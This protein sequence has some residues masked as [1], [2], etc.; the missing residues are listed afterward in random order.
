MHI[1]DVVAA[2]LVAVTLATCGPAYAAVY[3]E[4]LHAIELD[5]QRT[6]V[7]LLKRGVDVNT[8]DEKGDTLLILAARAGKPATVQ[9]LLAY[10]P[11]L[12][13]RN[14]VGESALMHAA[15]RGRED[16]VKMLLT[17]GAAVNQPGWTPLMYAAAGNQTDIA[18]LLL[19]RGAHVNATAQN[20][21]TALMMAARDGHL[22]M[23]LLLL[24]HGAD[25][26]YTS[27]FGFNALNVALER[28][29]RDVADVLVRAGAK[30]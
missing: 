30:P 2:V 14:G 7:G 15:I 8:V 25:V 1:R 5:D 4:I 21:T 9:T 19:A 6:I 18:R 10:K 26:N 13:A 24:E 22:P 27:A 29:R 3:Q 20:G 16:I 11:N 12:N 23:V 17:A 28:G